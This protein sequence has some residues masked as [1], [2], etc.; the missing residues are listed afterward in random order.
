[1]SNEL[2]MGNSSQGITQNKNLRAKDM[3]PPNVTVILPIYNEE[4]SIGSMV[5][6]KQELADR[7]IVV[8][9]SLKSCRYNDQLLE[10]STYFL[11]SLHGSFENSGLKI[12]N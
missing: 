1:M 2:Q 7:A 12:T 4:V 11:T 8:D 5:L 3:V 6:Q 9:N 10:R